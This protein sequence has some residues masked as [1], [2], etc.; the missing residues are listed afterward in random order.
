[1]QLELQN[2]IAVLLG[3]CAISITFAADDAKNAKGLQIGIKKRV[4]ADKCLIKSRKGDSLQM[5]YTVSMDCTDVVL[6]TAQVASLGTLAD[7]MWL[8]K[9]R[10]VQ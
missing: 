10:D 9:M 5:H 2:L 8:S 3:L 4:D 1:M 7:K 6:A